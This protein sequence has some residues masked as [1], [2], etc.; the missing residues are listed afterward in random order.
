M[1]LT[2]REQQQAIADGVFYF[3]T[4]HPVSID[5]ERAAQHAVKQ[6]LDEHRES[7]IEA[8]AERV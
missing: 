7:L 8:L 1:R 5:F 6:W 4:Q 3:L 2:T